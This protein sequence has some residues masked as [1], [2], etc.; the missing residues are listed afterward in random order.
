MSLSFSD[1]ESVRLLLFVVDPSSNA[2]YLTS[3][4]FLT[5]KSVQECKKNCW[6]WIGNPSLRV[7][8]FRHSEASPLAFLTTDW[9]S[10]KNMNAL[11]FVI[12][13]SVQPLSTS[14]PIVFHWVSDAQYSSSRAA[15][16]GTIYII[17]YLS[18]SLS[19]LQNPSGDPSHHTCCLLPPAVIG[20][21]SRDYHTQSSLLS[22]VKLW[23][24]ALLPVP[25]N[26]FVLC[27]SV[28][29]SQGNSAVI[30]STLRLSLPGLSIFPV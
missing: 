14:M 1:S 25:L 6:A 3:K 15:N 7:C 13:W 20:K 28:L 29:S 22:C 24:H 19:I 18:P 2:A 12:I 30:S 17:S 4:P 10:T 16:A 11:M 27:V 26:H 21:L 23:S 9:L 8:W 5:F